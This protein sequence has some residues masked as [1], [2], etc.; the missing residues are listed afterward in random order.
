MIHF[1]DFMKLH[2][3][4]ICRSHKGIWHGWRWNILY[5]RSRFGAMPTISVE[6]ILQIDEKL[7]GIQM[8]R[9]LH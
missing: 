7:Y 4:Y 1:Y 8:E 2:D 3:Y 5:K 6:L 9:K